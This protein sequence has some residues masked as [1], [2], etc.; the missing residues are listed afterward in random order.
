MILHESGKLS[1]RKLGWVDL[2]E[3]EAAIILREI[4]VQA[5]GA[6]VE[7]SPSFIKADEECPFTAFQ[8]RDN[9]LQRKGRFT[10]SC[11]AENQGAGTAIEPAIEELVEI[12]DAAQDRP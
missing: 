11:R 10:A 8:A 4:D 9:V 6:F 1:R 7:V 3:L 12:G 5:A 2:H